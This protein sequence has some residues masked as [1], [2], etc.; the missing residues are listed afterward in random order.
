MKNSIVKLI[1]GLVL[2]LL[3]SIGYSTYLKNETFFP[4]SAVNTIFT[5]IGVFF[6]V[7]MSLIIASPQVHIKNEIIKKNVIHVLKTVKST[8]MILFLLVSILYILI[9]NNDAEITIKILTINARD[10]FVAI[11]LY[12]LLKF[13]INF[14]DMY[15]LFQSVKDEMDKNLTD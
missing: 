10:I 15:N 1:V 4:N 7:G 14:N 13:V 8:Y 2:C 9:P 6:S 3:L 11:C 12:T 5:I